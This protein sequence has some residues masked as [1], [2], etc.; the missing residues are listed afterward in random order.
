MATQSP[1]GSKHVRT[2]LNLSA[3][4]QMRSYGFAHRFYFVGESA[5]GSI[6]VNSLELVCL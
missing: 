1:G 2:D 3:Y 6:E 4:L 5:T